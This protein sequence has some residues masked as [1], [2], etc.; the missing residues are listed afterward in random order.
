MIFG[1]EQCDR[2]HR[3]NLECGV[4]VVPNRGVGVCWRSFDVENGEAAQNEGEPN[5]WL[6]RDTS[7]IQKLETEHHS[8]FEFDWRKVEFEEIAQIET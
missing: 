3:H 2:H 5:R 4:D 7:A 1:Q 8:P 6:G